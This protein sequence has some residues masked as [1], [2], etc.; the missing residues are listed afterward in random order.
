MRFID[1]AIVLLALHVLTAETQQAQQWAY[2]PRVEGTNLEKRTFVLPEAF[3][4]DRNLVFI[5]FRRE[6]QADVDSWTPFLNELNLDA[7]AVIRYELPTLNRS[8][9]LV[10]SFI[11][12]GMARGIPDKSVRATTITLYIDKGPF[13]R[14]LGIAAEDRIVAFLVR[15]D[16]A[17]TWRADGAFTAE[18]GASL[19]AAL[20]ASSAKSPG[21][22]SVPPL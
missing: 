4:A 9:R 11:D 10:R 17:I 6:Q 15:R 7:R 3:E 1:G 14:A 2:F 20:V 5:A 18:A 13:K 8:Y 12:G 19:E 22:E 21:A 16:G